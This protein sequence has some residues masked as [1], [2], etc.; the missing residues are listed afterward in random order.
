[1]KIRTLGQ[2]Q[3]G[4]DKDLSWRVKEMA[5]MRGRI[6][7]ATSSPQLSYLRAALALLYAH[8]EGFIKNTSESYLAF[9]SNQGLTYR[10]LASCFVVFGAK[11][12]LM[13][14]VN[15]KQSEVNIAAVDFFRMQADSR[16]ALIMSGA[17]KTDSNLSSA[18]FENIALSIGVTFAPYAAYSNLI[19]KSLVDR[20]NKIAHG[21]YLEVDGSAFEE[22]L[23]EVLKL[24]RWYKTDIENLASTKAF[25]ITVQ[26]G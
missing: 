19:D 10:E 13:D 11:K 4:L 16:S 6:R 24:M 15:A 17:V 26:N 5:Y 25:K 18:V 3:D 9:V 2:L 1:M 23:Y 8:W 22:L 20:R 7:S 12:H 14:I 21:E